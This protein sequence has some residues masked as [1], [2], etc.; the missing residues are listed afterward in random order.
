M[1]HTR[2]FPTPGKKKKKFYDVLF[3]FSENLYIKEK[4]IVKRKKSPSYTSCDTQKGF[5]YEEKMKKQYTSYRGIKLYLPFQFQ[6][7]FQL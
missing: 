3:L 6:M 1:K 5:E 4:D 2:K 7:T